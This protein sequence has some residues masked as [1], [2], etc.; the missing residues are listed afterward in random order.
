MKYKLYKVMA[1]MADGK[2]NDE[3]LIFTFDIP[4]V[5]EKSVGITLS[6]MDSIHKIISVEETDLPATEIYDE[7]NQ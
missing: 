1:V 6:K 5:D 7:T 2:E 3:P 4:G